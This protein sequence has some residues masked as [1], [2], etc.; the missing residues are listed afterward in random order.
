[1]TNEELYVATA[2]LSDEALETLVNNAKVV[3]FYRLVA[4]S[5]L[6]TRSYHVTD[7]QRTIVKSALFHRSYGARPKV[8]RHG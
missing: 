3:D 8:R 6:K 7:E 5:L 2:W 1:M 4:A